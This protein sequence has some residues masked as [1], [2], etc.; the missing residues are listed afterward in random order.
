M[1]RAVPYFAWPRSIIIHF[2]ALAKELAKA[3]GNS[4]ALAENT[5][6]IRFW[7]ISIICA[8]I[9][10]ATLKLLIFLVLATAFS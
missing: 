7:L 9:G 10:L 2:E 8:L 6:V 5:V 3:Q 4:T 1:G